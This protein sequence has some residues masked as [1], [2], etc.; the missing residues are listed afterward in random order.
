M[1]HTQ[2]IRPKHLVK[3]QAARIAERHEFSAIRIPAAPSGP[4]PAEYAVIRQTAALPGGIDRTICGA[5]GRRDRF[6]M[7]R[8]AGLCGACYG[9]AVDRRAA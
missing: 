3:R 9:A 7:V 2:G 6:T 5:C 8:F 4:T 1:I